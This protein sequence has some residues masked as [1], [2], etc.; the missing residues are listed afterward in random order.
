MIR[1][2]LMSNLFE[3]LSVRNICRTGRFAGQTTNAFFGVMSCPRIR[4]QSALGFFPP[5]AKTP[6]GRIVLIAGHLIGRADRETET[7]VHAVRKHFAQ[8]RMSAM[9]LIRAGNRSGHDG[10]GLFLVSGRT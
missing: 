10:T 9:I 6:A 5:Q 3:N 1:N 8:R 2:M 7:A 4:C